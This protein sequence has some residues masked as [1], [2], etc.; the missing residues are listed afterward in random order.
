M[1]TEDSQTISEL[2]NEIAALKEQIKLSKEQE[3]QSQQ[4]LNKIKQIHKEFETSYLTAISEYKTIEENLKKQYFSYQSILENQFNQSEKRLNDQISHLKSV[5]K[6]KTD[7]ITQ[8][9]KENSELKQTITQNEID[10]NL[11]ENEY[12]NLLA[13][14]DKRLNELDNTIKEISEDAAEDLRKL[15]GKLEMLQ[16]KMQGSNSN[17]INEEG[18]NGYVEGEDGVNNKEMSSDRNYYQVV[19]ETEQ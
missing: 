7:L 1:D 8:L 6:T 2:K 17:I 3:T 10:F 9:T 19:Q 15:S 12:E 14:K 4:T 11:K 13:S 18:M 5:L 16:V